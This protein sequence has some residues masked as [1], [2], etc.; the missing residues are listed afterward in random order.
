MEMF[1]AIAGGGDHAFDLMI[2]AF[3]NG[4]QQ[5]GRVFQNG[6]GGADGFVVIVQ[7]DTVF[8][9]FSHRRHRQDVS[10]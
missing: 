6:F 2:F 1:D 3:G 9:A 7:Q 4:H 5:G 8:S 10:E